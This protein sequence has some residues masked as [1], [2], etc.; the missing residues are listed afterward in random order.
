MQ[1]AWPVGPSICRDLID[2]MVPRG[3]CEFIEALAKRAVPDRGVPERDRCPRLLH[4]RSSPNGV[5]Y[6]FGRLRRRPLRRRQHGRRRSPRCAVLLD[7]AA[8][9]PA[10]PGAGRGRPLPPRCCNQEIDGKPPIDHDKPPSMAPGA[11]RVAGLHT[12]RA[13]SGNII[14]HLALNRRIAKWLIDEP[15]IIPLAVEETLCDDMDHPR[16]RPRSRPCRWS[17][18]GVQLK[19]GEMAHGV[20]SGANLLTRGTGTVPDESA[21]LTGRRTTTSGSPAD[22]TCALGYH[23]AR[24]E[25]AVPPCRSGEGCPELRAR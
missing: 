16:P 19:K 2:P 12:T 21:S 1:S 25:M 20:A 4:C 8:R 3:E 10:R 6:F 18:H 22:R 23:L 15:E 5:D 7:R 17:S 11:L 14:H 9:Q 24:R 13:E